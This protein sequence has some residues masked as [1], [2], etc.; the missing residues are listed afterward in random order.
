M[1]LQGAMAV[2]PDNPGLSLLL[3]NV[4]VYNKMDVLYFLTKDV[5]YK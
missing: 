1:Y 3:W 2:Q 4:H 5:N